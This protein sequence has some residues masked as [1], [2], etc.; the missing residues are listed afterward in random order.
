MYFV[1][2]D[3]YTITLKVRFKFET[4]PFSH[5]AAEV[6][7]VETENMCNPDVKIHGTNISCTTK[8]SPVGKRM[9]FWTQVLRIYCAE[10]LWR[11]TIPSN[12]WSLRDGQR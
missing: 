5:T 10:H 7:E 9:M 3:C 8:R 4:T 1:R 11:R 12:L 6:S 2:L